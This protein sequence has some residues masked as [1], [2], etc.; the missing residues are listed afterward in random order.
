M[1][2]A[3]EGEEMS[4]PDYKSDPVLGQKVKDHLES[5][6]LETPMTDKVNMPEEQKIELIKGQMTEALKVL[7]LDLTDDSLMDTPNR[8]AKMW[9][10]EI[11]WGL[12]Y[13]QFPKCTT[14]ENKMGK[15]SPGSFVVE[16]NVNVQSNC[17]HHL[18]VID[19]KAC[20][21]YIPK[22]KVLGLSKLN[23]IVEFFAKRP[24]VQERLTE[25]IAATISF[26]TGTPDVAVYLE[27]VHY[28]VKSRGIQDTG[29]STC[30]LAVEGVF[31]DQQ[32]EMRR[33]FLN[34]A[35]GLS[36]LN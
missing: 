8:V 4:H 24:Q 17:E 30:T 7:G 21:A 25:Q 13:N 10:K 27:A 11:F 22:A 6:G 15:N 33:E 31:A 2:T 1:G 19:G 3:T 12:D 5:I 29:S 14:I 9:V 16:R 34:I 23:R 28:C 35:R 36:I 32:S 26:V 20:V 18:V